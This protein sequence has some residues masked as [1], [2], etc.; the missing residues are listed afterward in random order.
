[1]ARKRFVSAVSW[2]P[3]TYD[4][5]DVAIGPEATGAP[6]SW[7]F[8]YAGGVL[9]TMVLLCGATRPL[10]MKVESDTAP[11]GATGTTIAANASPRTIR[12]ILKCFR[13]IL[14]LPP[15]PTT[16]PGSKAVVTLEP[17]SAHRRPPFGNRPARGY[18]QARSRDG[19][20]HT[21]AAGGIRRRA[22]AL[23][24]RNTPAL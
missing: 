7:Y 11:A 17:R 9:S 19:L 5:S 4:R 21:R 12:R 6:T 2:V 18:F 23:A 15:N 14:F 3:A 13:N 22:C 8:R 10:S 16:R 24:G 20:P 1:M